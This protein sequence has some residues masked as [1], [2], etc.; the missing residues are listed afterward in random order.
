MV[1]DRQRL[2]K[3]ALD[4][5]VPHPRHGE[6]RNFQGKGYQQ[7]DTS[8]EHRRRITEQR[9]KRHDMAKNAVWALRREHSQQD[10]N[11]KGKNLCR[12]N[13][14]QRGGQTL[15]YHLGHGA[16]VEIRLTQIELEYPPDV[17]AQLH[18]DGLIQPVF[19]PD[20]RNQFGTC[21]AHISGNRVHHIARCQIDHG[22]IQ[23]QNSQQQQQPVK[24]ALRQY[25]Q[26]SH[27]PPPQ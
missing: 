8:P 5:H 14:E 16:V 27:A 1:R 25:D 4:R 18:D 15:E 22:E 20:L 26:K 21:P 11:H 7:Q 6:Q 9:K 3:K 13:Q 24:G 23:H 19:G 10:A 2:G 17:V 12:K